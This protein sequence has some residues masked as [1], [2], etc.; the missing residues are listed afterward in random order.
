MSTALL[1]AG[2]AAA[3]LTCVWSS[4][5]Y[6]KAARNWSYAQMVILWIFFLLK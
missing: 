1:I 5:G 4:Y 6:D 3:I 2:L